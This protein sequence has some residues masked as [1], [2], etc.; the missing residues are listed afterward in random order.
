MAGSQLS[1]KERGK[2]DAHLIDIFNNFHFKMKKMENGN[3]LPSA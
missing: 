1:G 3:G 2:G